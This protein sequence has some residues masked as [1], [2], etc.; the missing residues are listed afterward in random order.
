MCFGLRSWLARAAR[1]LN[2]LV[3]VFHYRVATTTERPSLK[4][5]V[6]TIFYNLIFQQPRYYMI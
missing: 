4:H 3:N 2:T 5:I 1:L 6:N